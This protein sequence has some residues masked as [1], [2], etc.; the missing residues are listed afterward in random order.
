MKI[1]NKKYFLVV[2]N[3]KKTAFLGA[4]FNIY[5]NYEKEITN[6]FRYPF[7]NTCFQK[8]FFRFGCKIFLE[9]L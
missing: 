2:L 6:P 1:K 5:Y 9:P 4:V 7:G 8:I 3:N